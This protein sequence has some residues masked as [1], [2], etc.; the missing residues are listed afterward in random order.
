MASYFVTAG[1]GEDE[2]DINGETVKAE[3][4]GAFDVRPQDKVA[5]ISKEIPSGLGG[6]CRD[7]GNKDGAKLPL[8]EEDLKKI[9]YDRV[10]WAQK[11]E[12]DALVSGLMKG[13]MAYLKT[14]HY[15]SNWR[16]TGETTERTNNQE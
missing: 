13:R 1:C 3:G 11:R 6:C 9:L 14:T 12:K 2:K 8:K 5:E 7:S 15:N 4:E 10:E 16:E